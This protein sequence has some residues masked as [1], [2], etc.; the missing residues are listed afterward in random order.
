M[1][2][3]KK[4][5]RLLNWA[6]G[7][8]APMTI[9]TDFSRSYKQAEERLQLLDSLDYG[10]LFSEARSANGKTNIIDYMN[11]DTTFEY[12][13]HFLRDR[14]YLL[15]HAP[16]MLKC[17]HDEAD[18]LCQIGAWTNEQ[19]REYRGTLGAITSGF[20]NR[21]KQFITAYKYLLDDD[22]PEPQQ[23]TLPQKLNTERAK[24][25][26]PKAIDD[27]LICY[28]NNKYTRGANVSKAL[29]AYF[30]RCIYKEGDFPDKE[31]SLLFGESRLG[32][33]VSQNMNNKTGYGKP[34]GYE[35]VDKLFE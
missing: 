27:G 10:A 29:L 3:T 21:L 6:Y 7:G 4:Y 18:R 34:R 35:R 26:F 22:R 9:G 19:W 31:L 25:Y 11:T 2:E 30:L 16:N 8:F 15:A 20:E 5:I 13:L 33:A 32:K 14:D 28:H 17:L 1:K 23:F 12:G 24:K